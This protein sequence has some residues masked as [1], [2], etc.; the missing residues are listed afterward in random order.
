MARYVWD[1]ARRTF[2]SRETGEPME[3]PE[4]EIA[5]PLICSDLPDYMS[6]L[7]TGLISGRAARREDLMRGNC[8]EV[9][10]GEFKKSEA[11]IEREARKAREART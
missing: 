3:L 7:G 5:A 11:F 10:P 8:R 1:R 4:R 2:V 6:P 9:A